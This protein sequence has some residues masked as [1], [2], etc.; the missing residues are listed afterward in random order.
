MVKQFLDTDSFNLT[1]K[2]K[3]AINQLFNL[4]IQKLDLTYVL[5][6]RIYNDGR[7]FYLSNRPDLMTWYFES[8]CYNYGQ[9]QRHPSVFKS[10]FVL[11]DS[12][13][14]YILDSVGWLKVGKPAAEKFNVAHG[15]TLFYQTSEFCDFIDFASHKGNVKINLNYLSNFKMLQHICEAYFSKATDLIRLADQKA[16]LLQYDGKLNFYQDKANNRIIPF[17]FNN[18]GQQIN[19]AELTNREIEVLKW[20]VE[21][22]TIPAIAIILGISTR[23]IEKYVYNIKEKLYCQTLFQVGKLV[24][25]YQEFFQTLFYEI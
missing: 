11:W 17:Q 25:N 15:I 4:L 5:H 6:R 9:C 23:T 14:S 24:G 18:N 20:L 19:L 8:N 1:I 21:G 7:H 12:W 13:K 2:S 3:S 10:G 16:A 22:K